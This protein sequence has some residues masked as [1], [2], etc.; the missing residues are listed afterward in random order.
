MRIS[1]SNSF[2]GSDFLTSS[3]IQTASVVVLRLPERF[4]DIVLCS[5]VGT[6]P[7][8]GYRHWLSSL[9]PV[10]PENIHSR[11][12]IT[13]NHG[14]PSE[15]R[16]LAGGCLPPTLFKFTAAVEYAVPAPH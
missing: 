6:R 5:N 11:T 15:T 2:G 8:V 3:G 9:E 10:N 12:P 16:L 1:G 14:A 7:W 13:Q 4:H